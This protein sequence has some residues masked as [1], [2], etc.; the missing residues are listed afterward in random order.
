MVGVV[1]GVVVG[2]CMLCVIFALRRRYELKA[3]TKLI[4]KTTIFVG[5]LSHMALSY[6]GLNVIRRTV[7]HIGLFVFISLPP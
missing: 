1:L 5:L 6:L 4:P 2:A 7:M 3:N